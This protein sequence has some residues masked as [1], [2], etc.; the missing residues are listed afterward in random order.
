[1]HDPSMPDID[2]RKLRRSLKTFQAHL[3]TLNSENWSFVT[4]DLFLLIQRDAIKA[5]Y[6]LPDILAVFAIPVQEGLYSVILLKAW[7]SAAA[8]TSLEVKKQ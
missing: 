2:P 8:R 1:M 7:L 4:Q 3:T 6:D 5:T